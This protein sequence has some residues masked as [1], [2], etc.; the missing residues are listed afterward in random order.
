MSA[1]GS[2]LADSVVDPSP[3]SSRCH[4]PR[5]RVS[6]AAYVAARYPGKVT[7]KWRMPGKGP[8]TKV[9]KVE[10]APLDVILALA[11]PAKKK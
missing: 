11:K 1:V 8:Q 3:R 2:V 10:D 7:V 5:V 4:G 6:P 9:V